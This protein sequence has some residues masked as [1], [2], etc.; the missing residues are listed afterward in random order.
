M[1]THECI[2]GHGILGSELKNKTGWDV[3]SKDNKFDI[4]DLYTY[5]LLMCRGGAIKECYYTTLINCIA[6]TNTYS[7]NKKGYD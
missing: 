7:S 2:L 1:S 5:Y 6:N 3:I 4:T